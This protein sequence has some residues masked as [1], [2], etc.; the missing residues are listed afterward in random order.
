MFL[1]KGC[2]RCGGDLASGLDDDVTCIQCGHELGGLGQ[3]ALSR[4]RARAVTADASRRN[5]VAAGQPLER[6]A[7]LINSA[8]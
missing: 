7:A 2:P 1:L 8:A 5:A 4:A 6:R 3:E